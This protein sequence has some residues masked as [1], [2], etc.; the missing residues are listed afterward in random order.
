MRWSPRF[1]PRMACRTF[2]CLHNPATAPGPTTSAKVLGPRR[3]ETLLALRRV[4]ASCR[5]SPKKEQG[6]APAAPWEGLGLQR[7][8]LRGGRTYPVAGIPAW[9][10]DRFAGTRRQIP[11]FAW[12]DLP[13]RLGGTGFRYHRRVVAAHWCGVRALGWTCQKQEGREPPCSRPSIRIRSRS[14]PACSRTS[15]TAPPSRK[16]TLDRDIPPS[17]RNRRRMLR[18]ASAR[19]PFRSPA[20]SPKGTSFDFTSP[21]STACIFPAKRARHNQGN[22]LFWAEENATFPDLPP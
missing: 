20:S 19:T 9:C 14:C 12:G 6:N 7:N 16:S 22:C 10:C 1:S 18:M 8:V 5:I 2:P 4:L 21:I 15:R 11:P 17:C 13:Y 3:D